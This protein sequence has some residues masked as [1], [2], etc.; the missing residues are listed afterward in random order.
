M[1]IE[2]QRQARA[3]AESVGH[4]Q[5]IDAGPSLR[6]ELLFDA[7]DRREAAGSGDG[8]GL[9]GL[10]AGDRA[11]HDEQRDDSNEWAHVCTLQRGR[12]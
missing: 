4:E 11:E 6:G 1:E 12:G 8:C 9:P 2:H 5:P 10:D 7:G 3:T